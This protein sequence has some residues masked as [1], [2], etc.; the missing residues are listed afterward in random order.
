MTNKDLYY[1]A[2]NCLSLDDHPEFRNEII[3]RSHTGRIDWMQFVGLCSNHFIL[4]VVF[5]K[6]KSHGI[7]KYLPEELSE[8]LN[9]IY[10]LNLSRNKQ[11]LAQAKKITEVLNKNNIFP[12]F[13]KGAG[14]LLDGLYSDTGERMMGDIDFLV[15][16]DD[17]LPAAKLMEREGYSKL[18]EKE[19]YTDIK[20]EKHYPRMAHPDFPAVIEIHRIPVNEE[21][22]KELN[23]KLID[24][25]KKPVTNLPGCFVLSDKHKIILNFVHSRF[26][27][28]QSAYGIVSLRDLYD[29]YLLSKRRALQ[30]TIA[31]IGNKPQAKIY[32]AFAKRVLALPD[33][34]FPPESFR[35]K[36]FLKKQDLFLRSTFLYRTY[37][38]SYFLSQRIFSGYLA[39]FFQMFYSKKVRQSVVSKLGSRSWYKNH[40][41]LY[42][43]FFDRNS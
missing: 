30:E 11:I 37:R 20:A 13:L 9:D 12:T 36:L 43:R 29:L 25:E 33:E 17:Y 34:F 28:D 18:Y 8:H 5:L 10:E 7:L 21:Q 38:T 35:F 1:F 32:F 3:E 42:N 2:G 22:L 27:D 19:N 39:Q 16:E 4:P 14:N 41:H 40:F 6:F 26:G 15:H 31:A 24:T 23:T